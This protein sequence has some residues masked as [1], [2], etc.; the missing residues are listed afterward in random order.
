MDKTNPIGPFRRILIEVSMFIVG[1]WMV[2]LFQLQDRTGV[3]IDLA[4]PELLKALALFSVLP[5]AIIG[6]FLWY[7]A[8]ADV[9]ILAPKPRLSN[10]LMASGS[11]LVSALVAFAMS[12]LFVLRYL[13]IPEKNLSGAPGDFM[14]SS[15]GFLDLD[16]RSTGSCDST[17]SK[18][19]ALAC[20]SH[21]LLH[22]EIFVVD[23]LLFFPRHSL[24][25]TLA[26][27]QQER[28]DMRKRG[29]V[30]VDFEHTTDRRASDK[31]ESSNPMM[32]V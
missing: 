26:Y 16:S 28:V 17:C 8:V 2:M 4:E 3:Y 32:A 13:Y 27:Y 25:R 6:S 7:C 15:F 1:L 24:E 10:I 22:I 19:L 31:E 12:S 14:S 9:F 5:A 18:S 21:L 20:V 30:N 23:L 29:S 11:Y